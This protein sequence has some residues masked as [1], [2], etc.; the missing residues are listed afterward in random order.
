M[1]YRENY[2]R[3]ESVY[4]GLYLTSGDEKLKMQLSERRNLMVSRKERIEVFEDTQAWIKED[5]YMR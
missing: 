3:I 2:D 1:T 4:D 5:K